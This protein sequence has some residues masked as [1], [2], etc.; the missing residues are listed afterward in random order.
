M[1]P[2][3]AAEINKGAIKLVFRALEEFIEDERGFGKR[4]LMPCEHYPPDKKR[5]VMQSCRC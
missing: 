3:T 5:S 4:S 1:R 2:R